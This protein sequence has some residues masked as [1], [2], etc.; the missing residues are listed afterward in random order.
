[1]MVQ[2]NKFLLNALLSIITCV[3]YYWSIK[4]AWYPNTRFQLYVIIFWINHSSEFYIGSLTNPKGKCRDPWYEGDCG[5]TR[6]NSI[7][8]HSNLHFVY[9]SSWTDFNCNAG[10]SR[11]KAWNDHLTEGRSRFLKFKL[12]P[13][14]VPSHGFP[15]CAIHSASTLR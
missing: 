7:I 9:L 5:H 10:D 4:I 1:M 13:R 12:S 14:W 2:S 15:S 6:N 8:A 11:H 3:F